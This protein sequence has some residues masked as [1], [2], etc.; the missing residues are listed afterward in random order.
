MKRVGEALRRHDIGD[1][2]PKVVDLVI[3]RMDS[4]TPAWAFVEGMG[5]DAPER[6]S[7]PL[8][9]KALLLVMG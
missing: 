2:H 6:Q 9:R 3:S 4:G 1:E 5:D 7:W 8:F